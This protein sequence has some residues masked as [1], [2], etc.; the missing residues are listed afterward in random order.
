[1]AFVS[2]WIAIERSLRF[3]PARARFANGVPAVAAPIVAELCPQNLPSLPSRQQAL[4]RLQVFDQISDLGFGQ[5]KEKMVVIVINDVTMCREAPVM[6]ETAFRPS[7]ETLEWS[8]SIPFIRRTVRLEIINANFC[9]R[10]HVPS[11]LCEKRGYMTGRTLRFAR[12]D[13]LAA[14]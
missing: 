3:D 11:R 6:V 9:R 13:R 14:D 7:K 4:E 2:Y 12:E 5:R 1:M 10:M 8:G